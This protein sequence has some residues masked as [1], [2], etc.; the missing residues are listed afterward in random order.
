MALANSVAK[1][2]DG[3]KEAV[4]PDISELELVDDD[5][6]SDEDLREISL[7]KLEKKQRLAYKIECL[8]HVSLA[9]EYFRPIS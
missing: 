5:E 7:E 2:E 1:T 9:R 6:E 4:P 3:G 8:C